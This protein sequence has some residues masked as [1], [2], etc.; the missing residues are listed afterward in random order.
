MSAS[1]E[2]TKVRV[3]ESYGWRD[4]SRVAERLKDS[5][6]A[7]GDYDV[8]IDEKTSEIKIEKYEGHLTA[9]R[10]NNC[11]F[12]TM[13]VVNEEI[14]QRYE[15]DSP[16]EL[17]KHYKCAYC[18]SVRATAFPISKKESDDYKQLRQKSRRNTKN[19]DVVK[20]EIHSVLSGKRFYEFPSVEQAQKFLEEFD[21][22]KTA[23]A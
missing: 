10:C 14:T 9:L 15:D 16:K 8:W 18:K 23:S 4:A 22:D 19:I 3:F 11:G 2:K 12:F 13:R 17:F 5:L 6:N 20:I 7:T 1:D 21:I